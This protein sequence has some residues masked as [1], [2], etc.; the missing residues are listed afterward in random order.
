LHIIHKSSYCDTTR[1]LRKILCIILSLTI[2]AGNS[3]MMILPTALIG[4]S[5]T[6]VVLW[7][8]GAFL[9]LVS[10]PFGGSFL[11]LLAGLPLTFL[12]RKQE[13]SIQASHPPAKAKE[14]A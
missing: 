3:K 2:T 13:R 11:A 5:V 12:E 10:A 6:I 8:Y 7:P 14:A 4:A 1:R 9:A